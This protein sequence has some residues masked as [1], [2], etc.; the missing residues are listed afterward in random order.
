[1][2]SNIK[3]LAATTLQFLNRTQLSA[4][5]IDMFNVCRNFLIQIAQEELTLSEIKQEDKE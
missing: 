5:E 1:M 3:Q 4:Q 2:D